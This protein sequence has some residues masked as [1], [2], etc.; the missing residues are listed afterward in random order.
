MRKSDSLSARLGARRRKTADGVLTSTTLRHR[1]WVGDAILTV[2]AGLVFMG[3]VWLPW[4]NANV[5]D[6]VNYSFSKPAA[7]NGAMATEFGLPVLIAGIAVVAVGLTMLVFGPNRLS[8]PLGLISA[9]ASLVVL[10][11]V[12]DAA[13]VIMPFYAGGLSLAMAF[14]TALVLPVIGPASAMVGAVLCARAR[15]ELAA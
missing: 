2:A 11:T 6:N 10:S 12:H 3:S 7:I 14:I 13:H 5:A 15:R 1:D 9:A 8:V 4:A